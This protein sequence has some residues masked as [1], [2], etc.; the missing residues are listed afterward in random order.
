M[1]QIL[2]ELRCSEN[3][4]T[5]SDLLCEDDTEVPDEVLTQLDIL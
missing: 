1:K 5:L 2:E 3:P 4:E